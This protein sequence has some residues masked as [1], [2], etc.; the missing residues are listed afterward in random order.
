[1]IAGCQIARI[2]SSD[3]VINP[4]KL[5]A[6]LQADTALHDLLF[7]RRLTISVTLNGIVNTTVIAIVG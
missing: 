1:M 4:W 7:H 5:T 2:A 3:N 6:K